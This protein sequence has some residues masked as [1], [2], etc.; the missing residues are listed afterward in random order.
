MP[1]TVSRPELELRPLVGDRLMGV[2]FERVAE[3]TDLSE[4]LLFWRLGLDLLRKIEMEGGFEPEEV[5]ELLFNLIALGE[6]L[7]KRIKTS[8]LPNAGEVRTSLETN[9]ECLLSKSS[10]WYGP[11]PKPENN[12]YLKALGV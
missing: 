1:D 7:K 5:R 9:I 4:Q 6:T 10:S 11:A 3:T 12:P 2:F 8:H